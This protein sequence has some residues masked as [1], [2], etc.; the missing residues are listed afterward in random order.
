MPAALLGCER[1]AD[2]AKALLISRQS[3][4]GR[5]VVT[6]QQQ[7]VVLRERFDHLRASPSAGVG[8]AVA[9]RTRA[10][11]DGSRQS[12]VDVGTEIRQVGSR[13]D[14]GI[15]GGGAPRASGRARRRSHRCRFANDVPATRGGGPGAG[16]ASRAGRSWRGPVGSGQKNGREDHGAGIT[17][18][19]I[20]ECSSDCRIGSRLDAVGAIAAR[21]CDDAHPNRAL[22]AGRDATP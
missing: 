8:L 15:A 22:G 2:G 10:V 12:L 14:R 6:L 11:L 4:W 16:L 5:S 1:S 7:E 19:P 3:D 9:A 17:G 20:L 18:S 21:V 13:F